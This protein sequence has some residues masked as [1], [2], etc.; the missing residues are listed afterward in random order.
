MKTAALPPPNRLVFTR[1]R[2]L[3]LPLPA[4]G[5]QYYYDTQTPSLAC[6][7]TSAGS[8]VL[9]VYRKHNGRPE[10]YRLGTVEELPVETARKNTLAHIAAQLAGKD[11][12]QERLAKRA[13]MD[14]GE[15]F[16]HWLENYAKQRKKTWRE[17]EKQ[18]A[19]YLSKWKGRRLSTIRKPDVQTLHARIGEKNGKYAAN[20][21]LELL[22][23][24]FVKAIDELGV[25]IPN[26]AKGVKPFQEKSRERFLHP[27]EFPKFWKALESEPSVV[28]RDF[29]K[30]CLFTGARRGN[31]LTMRWDDVHLERGTWHI[32]DTKSG[33]PQTVTLSPEVTEVLEERLANRVDGVPWVFPGHVGGTHLKDPYKPWRAV[34]KRAGLANLRIHDLRR[35]L[36]SWQVIN[37]SS[38]HVTGKSL[39][40]KTA[41]AT[42][43]YARL[44]LDPVRASVNRA[45]AAMLHVAAGTPKPTTKKKTASKGKGASNGKAK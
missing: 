31:V 36:G 41:S 26:P 15:L 34:L 18:F 5:R 10:R 37:G 19:R 1:A 21:M 25:Q 22:H 4:T 42:A 39:G 2:L 27:D 13:E 40:H 29:F 23:A 3:A 7:V 12:H 28:C 14:L 11:P 9:Y 44:D 20:R 17:D 38:L 43:V 24:L 8:R 45:T 35:T 33:V 30:V 32:P 16:S 6:C